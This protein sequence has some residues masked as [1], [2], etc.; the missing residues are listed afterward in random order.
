[1]KVKVVKRTT[2]T[3]GL[4]ALENADA[5]TRSQ[6]AMNL[7]K[8]PQHSCGDCESR[9]PRSQ[10]RRCCP[11][12]EVPSHRPRPIDIRIPHTSSPQGEASRGKVETRNRLRTCRPLGEQ[13]PRKISGPTADVEHARIRT[14]QNLAKR[15]RRKAPP[16]A[17]E[18]KRQQMIRAVICRCDGAEELPHMF[19]SF[20]LGAL[21][22][23]TRALDLFM[24]AAF[25]FRWRGN[26]IHGNAPLS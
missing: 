16:S 11:G 20:A 5:A 3:A 19:C 8:T 7:S 14:C 23:R 12:R 2:Q 15:Y 18:P 17:I 6:H 1:M 22:R 24:F 25:V 21:R 4:I 10:G 13:R 26:V 9:T